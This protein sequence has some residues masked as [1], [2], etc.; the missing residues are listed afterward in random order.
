MG[1]FSKLGVTL[2]TIGALLAGLGLMFKFYAYDRLATIPL[3]QSTEAVL[4]D[5]NATFFDADNV[6]QGAGRLTTTARVIAD[7]ALSEEA[8]DETG[9]D[10][11]VVKMG[12]AS[13]NNDQA[14]PMDFTE[15]VVALDRH[16]GEALDWSGNEQNGEPVDFQGAQVIKFPFN[17]Q[18]QDYEYWDG[19]LGQPVTMEYVGTETVEGT[20]GEIETYK[21]ETSI[22]ESITSTREVPRGLFGLEDTGPVVADRTYANDR[23]IWVEPETGVMIKIQEAQ[24]QR[25]L[26][27]D[28]GAVP[29]Q[30]LDTVSA[31]TDET[32]DANIEEYGSKVG[33]LGA[34]RTFLPWTLLA[35]GLVLI[36]AGVAVSLSSSKK[37]TEV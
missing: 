8:S 15:R 37:R 25:L 23:T 5:D 1:K 24:K 14:P 19:T 30:A 35:I 3:D 22:P 17:T 9:R 26:I 32:V 2:V 34:I 16:T 33:V 11:V 10:A 18:Q 4:T 7:K 31:S 27:D 20:D 28:E 36:L 12:Q 6:G 21:F 29:V 13:D